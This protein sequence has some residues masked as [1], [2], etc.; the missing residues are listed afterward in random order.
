MLPASRR[1][2]MVSNSSAEMSVAI[3]AADECVLAVELMFSS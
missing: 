2:E 3:A 1:Q